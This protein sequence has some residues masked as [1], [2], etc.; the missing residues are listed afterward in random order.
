MHIEPRRN[1]EH[2]KGG[3]GWG[4]NN[5]L[6]LFCHLKGS[7]LLSLRSSGYPVMRQILCAFKR[8]ER[9]PSLT[10]PLLPFSHPCPTPTFHSGTPAHP[11]STLERGTPAHPAFHCAIV[12]GGDRRGGRTR[13]SQRPASSK[14]G[15]RVR[16]GI[17]ATACGRRSA[18][19][20][21]RRGK[22]LPAASTDLSS[23]TASDYLSVEALAPPAN[24][25]FPK[26]SIL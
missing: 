11:P 22:H 21:A 25:L 10:P 13:L 8:Q 3:V 15:A 2:Y 18:T 23:F 9:N 20:P 14:A 5:V 16:R 19:N 7:F 24:L 1:T 12:R 6:Y 17:I 4:I 26:K